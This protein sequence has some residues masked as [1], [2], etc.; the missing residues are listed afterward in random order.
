M[1]YG[2]ACVVY[3]CGKIRLKSEVS[4]HEFPHH[5][6]RNW[7]RLGHVL[8]SQ[9]KT[10]DVPT[11]QHPYVANILLVTNVR[12][13]CNTIWGWRRNQRKMTSPTEGTDF[14][15]RRPYSI[16]AHINMTHPPPVTSVTVSVPMS[17]AVRKRGTRGLSVTARRWDI[18]K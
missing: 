18:T 17:P 13:K 11:A 3:G 2:L 4:V 1:K 6:Q 10:N 15:E 5:L 7:G 12:I 8:S 14:D 16:G 9:Q